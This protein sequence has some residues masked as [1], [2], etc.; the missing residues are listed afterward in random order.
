M[1]P[2]GHPLW[3]LLLAGAL[4][5]YGTVTVIVAVLGAREVRALFVRETRANAFGSARG[6]ARADEARSHRSACC[7]DEL[8]HRPARGDPA[9]P[10]RKDPS[11]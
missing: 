8:P 2:A 9:D 1:S 11:R 4:A 6:S 7:D 5:W 10:D 3:W